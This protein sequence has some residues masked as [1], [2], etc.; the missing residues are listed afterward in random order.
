MNIKQQILKKLMYSKG[1]SYNALRDEV[2]SNKFTY[3]LNQLVE[4]DIIKK[5]ILSTHL[6]QK[7]PT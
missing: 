4:D 5:K 7:E 3:H 2:P 1:M 6:L